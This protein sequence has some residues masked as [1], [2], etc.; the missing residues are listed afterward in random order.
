MGAGGS[1]LFTLTV[2]EA[3]ALADRLNSVADLAD[4]HW[5]VTR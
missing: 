4:G 1:A 2:G 5:A 3:R